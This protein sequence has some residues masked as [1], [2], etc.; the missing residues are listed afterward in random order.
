MNERLEIDGTRLPPFLAAKNLKNHIYHSVIE[1]TKLIKYQDGNATKTGYA[2]TLLP[3][4]NFL[5]GFGD[6]CF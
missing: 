3:N 6:S 1:W 4:G 5:G 2:A